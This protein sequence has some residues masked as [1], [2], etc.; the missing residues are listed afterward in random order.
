ML[1]IT[2]ARPIA[3]VDRTPEFC[4]SGVGGDPGMLEQTPC[5]W[6]FNYWGSRR[7]DPS[8]AGHASTGLLED[9]V[10]ALP[11]AS[12]QHPTP[13]EILRPSIASGILGPNLLVRA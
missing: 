5:E 9:R 7:R 8:I 4:D 13:H 6:F 10:P 3:C 12:A 2:R 11:K 1:A